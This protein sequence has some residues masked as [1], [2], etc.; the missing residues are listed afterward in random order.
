M[1]YDI[2]KKIDIICYN[3]VKGIEQTEII[4]N[5]NPDIKFIPITNM[6][7]NEIIE[8]LK[9]SKVY[10][11]FGNHPG[12]DR[13]PRESAILGNCVITNLK[14]AAGFKE[15]VLIDDKYKVSDI[16]LAGDI[17]RYCFNNFEESINDFKIY[18]E[19]ISNQ[20]TEFYNQIKKYL[21]Q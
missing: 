19:Y 6:T 9:I 21:I 11:D 5:M 13:L 18:R 20:K 1:T 14:G 4:K 16:N 3:P 8:L 15:D 2:S 12:R 7:E 17:I 10:I